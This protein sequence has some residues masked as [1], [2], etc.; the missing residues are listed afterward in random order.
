MSDVDV[1]TLWV[2]V[3][4]TH[5][6]RFE[7]VRVVSTPYRGSPSGTLRN[8]EKTA[9]KIDAETWTVDEHRTQGKRFTVKR[10]DMMLDNL[11]RSHSYRRMNNEDYKM[12]MRVVF[13]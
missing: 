10:I 2:H 11:M 3:E 13:A 1:G 6:Y 8:A 4:L 9:W 5:G 7:L 12:C